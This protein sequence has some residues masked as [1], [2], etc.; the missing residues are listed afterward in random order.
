MISERTMWGSGQ[1]VATDVDVAYIDDK[2]YPIN[3]NELVR[4][5]APEDVPLAAA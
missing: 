3:K 5:C 2:A 1:A 4:A